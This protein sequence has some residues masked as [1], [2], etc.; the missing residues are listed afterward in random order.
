MEKLC[1][2]SG[3]GSLDQEFCKRLTRSFNN[4]KDRTGKPAIKWTEVKSWFQERQQSYSYKNASSPNSPKNFSVVPEACPNKTEASPQA[5]KGE[6]VPDLSD[7]EFE[8]RSSKDGAWYDVDRFITHRFLSSGEP[9]VRVRYVGFGAEEDE[10]VNVKRAIRERS[11]P[12][13]HSECG[14]LRVGDLV[15]CF[16]ET[17]EQ[18]RYYDAHI[19]EILRRMHDIRGCRCLF[20]IQYDHDQTKERVHLRRL[21]CRPTY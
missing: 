11:L 13:E 17:R 15:L 8:A 1:K 10:W 12:L 7:L 21:C 2:E 16:Q 9:E 14:K 18:A 6:K 19:I 4:S 20:L 3:T 5:S